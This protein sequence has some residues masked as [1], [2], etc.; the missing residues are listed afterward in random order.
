M[1][2]R[3]AGPQPAQRRLRRNVPD[4]G[5]RGAIRLRGAASGTRSRGAVV[6]ELALMTPFLALL[7]MGMCEIAQTLR[8]EAILTQ[9]A[10]KGCAAGS[11]P[12][13]SNADVTYDVQQSLAA[14][15]IP[16]TAATI[17]ILVNDQPGNVASARRN[18]KITVTVGIPTSQATWT[19]TNVFVGRNLLQS[20]A[21]IMMKQG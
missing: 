11:R 5:Q 15:G 14:G 13:C 20:E 8:V 16:Q 17:T 2:N 3:L 12:G 1:R 7:M 6:V 21:M 19:G 18:D 10:R 9:A 4:L